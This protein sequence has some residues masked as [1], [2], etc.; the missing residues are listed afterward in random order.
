MLVFP[1]S[2]ANKTY[3]CK[4][5]LNGRD[6][7]CSP[8]LP[9]TKDSSGNFNNEL[10]VDP[11]DFIPTVNRDITKAKSIL[12]HLHVKMANLGYNEMHVHM[13]SDDVI[14]LIRQEPETLQSYVLIARSAFGPGGKEVVGDI[15]LPGELKSVEFVGHLHVPPQTFVRNPD[16]VNGLL[17]QLTI[18]QSL[19]Q[20]AHKSF[21][22]SEGIDRLDFFDIPQAFVCVLKV[23]PSEII[24]QALTTLKE[25]YKLLEKP[26]MSRA[27]F[28]ELTLEQINHVLWRCSA[29][30]KDITD[31][32]RGC[33][34]IPRHRPFVYSGIGGLISE[35]KPLVR[36]NALGHPIFDNIRAG[37]WL[38]DYHISR[39]I[40]YPLPQAFK[41][42]FAKAF[43]S[44]KDLPAGVICKHFV[45][46]VFTLFRRLKLHI[47]KD[48]YRKGSIYHSMSDSLAEELGLAVTQLIGT[49]PSARTHITEWTLSAGLP[50]FSAGYMRAWGR[51]TFIAFRGLLLATGL[52]NEARL[53]LLTFA[54]TMRHGLIPN[55]LD[56]GKNCRYNARDATWFFLQA[57]QDYIKCSDEGAAV[58]QAEVFMRYKSDH[59]EEHSRISEQ[60]K[61]SVGSI[62]QAILQKHAIGI[63]FREW[64]A[65][66]RI[67]AHMT[68]H[69]FDVNIRLDKTT[70]F[71][72]GGNRYNC[73]TWM[74]K[75]GSSDKARNRG[76]PATPRDG[77]PVE[78][79]GLLYSTLKFF[80]EL[81]EEGLFHSQG[82]MLPNDTRL[83]FKDWAQLIQQHFEPSYWIPKVEGRITGY[84]RDT[85]GSEVADADLKLRPNQCIALAVAPELFVPSHA[86]QALQV[87]ERHLLPQIDGGQIGVRTLNQEDPAYRPIYDNSNDSTD[88]SVAHGFS[89]HNGPEWLWPLG[90][91]IRA[92]LHFVKVNDPQIAGRYLRSTRAFIEDSLWMSLPELTN[93]EGKHCSFSCDSQAWSI[94]PLLDVFLDLS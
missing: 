23:G 17:G 67:D 75:M 64:N 5:I 13:A 60:V 22:A 72:H 47:I 46:L 8:S 71:I 42:I 80:G 10:I 65:G 59:F 57:L 55:L 88:P 58:L 26:E 7:V 81:H 93:A 19:S 90:Y 63:N 87:I 29:E 9:Q 44:L 76:V 31:G 16:Y 82:V 35:L 38:I 54:S 51:D 12:N 27:G 61:L 86:Q 11:T 20:Y 37:P 78:L 89:Y 1:S 73:G 85:L 33:Y 91:F 79:T 15:R 49:V 92:R 36:E 25:T 52:Y 83:S 40:S 66:T 77:A 70:G 30:E 56:G 69:G 21:I 74:D 3:P 28:A 84:Y 62:V 45:K 2:A 50:H 68:E 53:V 94:G 14:M 32:N 41:E 43:T 4:F 18:S 34:E 48:L 24:R 6:W 39:V